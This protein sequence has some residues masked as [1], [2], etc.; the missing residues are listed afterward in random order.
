M[1]AAQF[2]G[3]TSVYR[4]S[5]QRAQQ[6]GEAC[7]EHAGTCA[8]TAQRGRDN[9]HTQLPRLRTVL[10]ACLPTPCERAEDDGHSKKG[11]KGGRVAQSLDF[12]S[13]STSS[14]V[15]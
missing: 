7:R 5:A 14:G 9:R 8:H 10:Q 4:Q 6:R 2:S 3:A 11:K 15:V 12:D 13:R 1:P